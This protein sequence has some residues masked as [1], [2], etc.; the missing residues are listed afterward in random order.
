MAIA[1]IKIPWRIVSGLA[2]AALLML[3]ARP[4]P[5]AAAAPGPQMGGGERH[6]YVT[7]ANYNGAQALTACGAGYHFAALW[8]IADVTGLVYDAAYPGARTQADI[9]KGPPAS[10]FGWVRTGRESAV[11][12]TAGT[13]NCD[14]WTSGTA[15]EYGTIARLTSTWWGGGA[16]VGPWDASTWACSGIAPVWCVR[17]VTISHLP[18]IR[19]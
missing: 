4:V 19:R 5:P 7:A 14:A 2:A 8:E 13:A 15:G 1:R 6:F 3:A 9:G 18:Y 16:D 12:N 10:W 17:D 11:T